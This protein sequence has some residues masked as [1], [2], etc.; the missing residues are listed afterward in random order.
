MR[1]EINCGI[2]T[3]TIST[4]V[5][6]QKREKQ[7]TG[8]QTH[9][10]KRVMTLG[11]TN[12]QLLREER[13]SS[14]DSADLYPIYS[15][16]KAEEKTKSSPSHSYQDQRQQNRNSAGRRNENPRYNGPRK[17]SERFTEHEEGIRWKPGMFCQA[18]YWEDGQVYCNF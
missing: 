14:L 8:E 11:E 5:D 4:A 1:A 10:P 16:E 18:I 12:K 6:L 2:E 7:Q 15:N 17:R 13:S 3:F 9:D